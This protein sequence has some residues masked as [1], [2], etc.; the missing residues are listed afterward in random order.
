MLNTTS[1]NDGRQIFIAPFNMAGERGDYDNGLLY[2]QPAFPRNLDMSLATAVSLSGRFPWV[3]PASTVGSDQFAVVDGAYFESSG[4]ETLSMV[5]NELR[6]YEVAPTGGSE[7]PYIKVYVIVIGS[8]SP[9][10]DDS[11]LVLDEA[12]PPVRTL[13]KARD[14]RGYNAFSTLR[15]WDANVECPPRRPE[16]KIENPTECT[17]TL[18][19][20]FRLNYDYFNLPLGWTLSDGVSQIIEQHVHGRCRDNPDPSDLSSDPRKIL[21][22]NK[23]SGE[24]FVPYYLTPSKQRPPAVPDPCPRSQR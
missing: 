18:P 15:S 8:L 9:P 3:M 13:L 21:E 11:P 12:T 6:Q 5:R 14:R 2:W 19:V 7:Y 16:S 20:V 4:I 17:P 23:L 24:A 22:E 10:A 1:V